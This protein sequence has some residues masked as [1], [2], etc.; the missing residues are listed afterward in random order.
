MIYNLVLISN[1]N[2]FNYEKSLIRNTIVPKLNQ[3]YDKH[4]FNYID[5]E[6]ECGDI[7]DEREATLALFER[8]NFTLNNDRNI[9]IVCI[10]DNYGYL[11][12]E[13]EYA[14]YKKIKGAPE[15]PSSILEYQATIAG[16][17]SSKNK[18]FMVL[19]RNFYNRPDFKGNVFV[20]NENLHLLR[21][22]RY[23]IKDY[24]NVRI[25]DYPAFL[26]SLS[27]Y[28]PMSPDLFPGA[29]LKRI[30]EHLE[31]EMNRVYE[32]SE[33]NSVNDQ[34]S[35]IKYL[36]NKY[37]EKPL[38]A[39]QESEEYYKGIFIDNYQKVLNNIKPGTLYKPSFYLPINQ[40]NLGMYHLYLETKKR[41]NSL[42]L[43]F[44]F[45]ACKGDELEKYFFEVLA[46]QFNIY[47][48][49]KKYSIIDALNSLEPSNNYYLFIAN[50]PE[51][52]PIKFDKLFKNILPPFVSV[53]LSYDLSSLYHD[54]AIKK[55]YLAVMLS[56]ANKMSMRFVYE[57]VHSCKEEKRLGEA[58]NNLLTNHD[59]LF[60]FD[61]NNYLHSKYHLFEDYILDS[62]DFT[63]LLKCLNELGN[64]YSNVDKRLYKEIMMIKSSFLINYYSS[65]HNDPSYY[66]VKSLLNIPLD[67]LDFSLSNIDRKEQIDFILEYDED[68]VQTYFYLLSNYD[69]DELHTVYE[70]NNDIAFEEA[71]A[72]PSYGQQDYI[73][74]FLLYDAFINSSDVLVYRYL[75][76]MKEEDIEFNPV[77]LPYI[78]YF[79]RKYGLDTLESF[80]E[81]YDDEELFSVYLFNVLTL[82]YY[83]PNSYYQDFFDVFLRNN[84]KVAAYK[85]SKIYKYI[86]SDEADMYTML[87][88]QLKKKHLPEDIFT[89][90]E[91]ILLDYNNCSYVFRKNTAFN[92][93]VYE[94]VLAT[95][96]EQE[97][98]NYFDLKKA[99]LEFLYYKRNYTHYELNIVV[100][101]IKDLN[102]HGIE[103]YEEVD[104]YDYLYEAYYQAKNEV[105][106]SLTSAKRL[107]IVVFELISNLND[108]GYTAF[109]DMIL[110]DSAFYNFMKEDVEPLKKHFLK[111]YFNPM[112]EKGKFQNFDGIV[113]YFFKNLARDAK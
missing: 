73:S 44:D 54:E 100:D 104:L 30:Q 90:I 23:R 109:I 92:R 24:S 39:K 15:Y 35:Y 11:P 70:M 48:A 1:F 47:I 19:V 101:I 26:T 61:N 36:E 10:S 88:L 95:Y 50:I 87:F 27:T 29:L 108:D 94:Y 72:A 85:F 46:Y 45:N 113:D 22:F 58:F 107:I 89:K 99:L 111:T 49:D 69:E 17:F 53:V 67:D 41:E 20:K 74:N 34:K 5:Y 2:D 65:H 42:C 13:E 66:E 110:L 14:K 51:F 21:E 7:T 6:L 56:F 16:L 93:L 96:K 91:N 8:S 60:Y 31:D 78:H 105:G 12:S 64:K 84:I 28:E 59:G 4:I 33:F 102:L 80:D 18:E 71:L 25:F 98:P 75:G 103:I 97:K 81:G 32:T 62:Y 55:E 76:R 63:G 77:N 68:K 9:Y 112:K 83:A 52:F 82:F 106:F 40:L 79:A 37:K 43:Y 57:F 38:E 86:S 3:I